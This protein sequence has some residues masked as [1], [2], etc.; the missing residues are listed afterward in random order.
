MFRIG[1]VASK[2]Q[3]SATVGHRLE[4]FIASKR[5]MAPQK[6]EL[7]RVCRVTVISLNL[8]EMFVGSG[9]FGSM[10]DRFT[11]PSGRGSRY[12]HRRNRATVQDCARGTLPVCD[13]CA[14]KSAKKRMWCNGL[15]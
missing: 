2:W 4:D 6:R 12:W 15:W 11:P 8:G 14:K 9:R 5:E 3:N 7:V 13:E 1:S 10:P